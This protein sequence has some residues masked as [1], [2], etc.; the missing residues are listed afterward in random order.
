MPN[1]SIPQRLETKK[2]EKS[3]I[4]TSQDK[5]NAILEKIKHALLNISHIEKMRIAEFI[6]SNSI[7]DGLNV[8]NL[9]KL[10][11]DDVGMLVSDYLFIIKQR[12]AVEYIESYYR[13]L[14][15]GGA[16]I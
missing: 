4:E 6:F 15:P 2:S 14:H 7:R 11:K 5:W 16:R 13:K 12:E 3:S 1:E 9:L 10:H 8:V